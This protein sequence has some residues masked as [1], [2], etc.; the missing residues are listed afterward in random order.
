MSRVILIE[1]KLTKRGNSG[2]KSFSDRMIRI[3]EEGG[4]RAVEYYEMKN[5]SK[6]STPRGRLTINKR[7]C[8]W[9]PK[10]KFK[11]KLDT[12]VIFDAPSNISPESVNDFPYKDVSIFFDIAPDPKFIFCVPIDFSKW[13]SAFESACSA[14]RH[15]AI[16][17]NLPSPERNFIGLTNSLALPPVNADF[18]STGPSFLSP[19]NGANSSSTSFIELDDDRL[20]LTN[21][22]L[23]NRVDDKNESSN[24][25]SVLDEDK[26]KLSKSSSK[27]I[28]PLLHLGNLNSSP[29]S[30]EI[31]NA[32]Q[33][34]QPDLELIAA[35]SQVLQA[36]GLLELEHDPIEILMGGTLVKRGA[37]GLKRW[38]PRAFCLGRGSTDRGGATLTY[39]EEPDINAIYPNFN[40]RKFVNGLP[41][42]RGRLF[43]EPSTVIWGQDED[44]KGRR[45]VILVFRADTREIARSIEAMS[46]KAVLNELS[47]AKGAKFILAADSEEIKFQ[48]VDSIKK[49]VEN[50]LYYADDQAAAKRNDE[51]DDKQSIV[52]SS[53]GSLVSFASSFWASMAGANQSSSMNLSPRLRENQTFRLADNNNILDV[54]SKKS[55]RN[56]T[57]NI[58]SAQHNFNHSKNNLSIN[59]ISHS[60]GIMSALATPSLRHSPRDDK[61]LAELIHKQ[62]SMF[63]DVNE[64]LPR[65]SVAT[66]LATA[67]W[68]EDSCE[69]DDHPETDK[70][71]STAG[72]VYDNMIKVSNTEVNIKHE[73]E[74]QLHERE[75]VLRDTEEQLKI[76]SES[77]DKEKRQLQ[78]E[79]SAL[80][81]NMEDLNNEMKKLDESLIKDTEEQRMFNNEKI[82]FEV[83]CAERIQSLRSHEESAEK[84]KKTYE[85]EL[86]KLNLQKDHLTSEL[87]NFENLKYAFDCEK[88][89]LSDLKLT[90]DKE[91]DLF[92]EKVNDVEDKLKAFELRNSELS[93]AEF[94][95]KTEKSDFEVEK[96]NFKISTSN[97]Q[98]EKEEFSIRQITNDSETQQIISN[99]KKNMEELEAS[100]TK[101]NE[102]KIHSQLELECQN[103]AFDMMKKDFSTQ[104]AILKAEREGWKLRSLTALERIQELEKLTED[105]EGSS[106]IKMTESRLE[107]KELLEKIK[108]YEIQI[109]EFDIINRDLEKMKNIL[110]EKNK[111]LTNSVA[112][113]TSSANQCQNNSST[114]LV[115]PVNTYINR[116]QVE[117]ASLG[118]NIDRSMLVACVQQRIEDGSIS[119]GLTTP[120]GKF[121][122]AEGFEIDFSSPIEPIK[123]EILMEMM[124][125]NF[126][127]SSPGINSVKLKEKRL[128]RMFAALEGN[129]E[130]SEV[131]ENVN[132][133]SRSDF[134]K[135]A[136][137]SDSK[138]NNLNVSTTSVSDSKTKPQNILLWGKASYLDVNP[139]LASPLS[140]LIITGT[141]SSIPNLPNNL[142]PP[143]L[144]S[145]KATSNNF[146]NSASLVSSSPRRLN[147]GMVTMSRRSSISSVTSLNH[148][149]QLINSDALNFING[150]PSCIPMTSDE[151]PTKMV[152][153]HS[154]SQKFI[155][156]IAAL[157]ASAINPQAPNRLCIYRTK[158]DAISDL[159]A[160]AVVPICEQTVCNF[161]DG[162]RSFDPMN[163]LIFIASGSAPLRTAQ[164]VTANH[165]AN[166][167]ELIRAFDRSSGPK[168]TISIAQGGSASFFTKL[169]TLIDDWLFPFRESMLSFA[170]L[171]M[172]AAVSPSPPASILNGNKA[173]I[174]TKMQAPNLSLS[175]SSNSSIDHNYNDIATSKSDKANLLE[176]DIA[177]L[178]N[179]AE[180]SKNSENLI[181]VSKVD[182]Q[183]IVLNPPLEIK[184]LG[185][186]TIARRGAAEELERLRH[187]YHVHDWSED[188]ILP[189]IEFSIPPLPSY[190]HISADPITGF[191]G[192]KLHM[193]SEPIKQR[194][195]SNTANHIPNND[196]NKVDLHSE[197]RTFQIE[198][199][200]DF[201]RTERQG[202]IVSLISDSSSGAVASSP[203]PRNI[204]I[205]G[206][207]DASE[208][209][210]SSSTEYPIWLMTSGIPIMSKTSFKNPNSSS[211][212]L[213]SVINL[214]SLYV[215]FSQSSDPS[216]VLQQDLVN[217]TLASGQHQIV[218]NQSDFQYGQDSLHGNYFTAAD[219]DKSFVPP[220]KTVD[221]KQKSGKSTLSKTKSPTRL[222]SKVS[223]KQ[224]SVSPTSVTITNTNNKTIIHKNSEESTKSPSG[225]KFV[226]H[227]VSFASSAPIYSS[228]A[229]RSASTP[230]AN[231]FPFSPRIIHTP[232]NSI[233]LVND[234]ENIYHVSPNR[235]SMT[236]SPPPP[237]PPLSNA[238]LLP[239]PPT[240][241]TLTPFTQ[242]LMRQTAL[243]E[244][245]LIAATTCMDHG[246]SPPVMYERL[247]PH[248]AATPS[249]TDP[250]TEFYLSRDGSIRPVSPQSPALSTRDNLPVT[251][252]VREYRVPLRTSLTSTSTGGDMTN[253]FLERDQSSPVKCCGIFNSPSPNPVLR[254]FVPNAATEKKIGSNLVKEWNE[255]R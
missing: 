94:I 78:N 171:N 233:H 183:F 187:S 71:S 136:T 108:S 143:N 174:S 109:A 147:E 86:E 213:Q 21:S 127:D 67:P 119:T 110:E 64:Q 176:H 255:E 172:K 184:G 198:K 34:P 201:S 242:A 191:L 222:K 137:I 125:N 138:N 209:S 248:H 210:T 63:Q 236:V 111:D 217:D 14:A 180:V 161:K 140:N 96:Q 244:K 154:P 133:E 76:L 77:I 51:N 211:E 52:S 177:R 215:L 153:N 17:R 75:N 79:R 251:L 186:L 188:N 234:G 199:P 74:T 250:Q 65:Q 189:A 144:I 25:V 156:V 106:E 42:A 192:L 135:N 28:V 208:L 48:W 116:I 232:H 22:L 148:H 228:G 80:Q 151:F 104:D 20:I 31:V 62:E 124:L 175:V 169:K 149:K 194:V 46:A 122:A 24:L 196:D 13:Q 164:S 130:D 27:P 97:F 18:G 240:R 238:R 249:P 39:F 229:Q 252:S 7:T 69:D 33:H 12:I 54:Q 3:V 88:T 36:S 247:S 112:V 1:G 206:D 49:A 254:S 146:G 60:N 203:V 15:D 35:A 245:S 168:I 56:Q 128:S 179:Q 115:V 103:E 83:E 132:S 4:T 231:P 11:G 152:L 72:G 117:M 29:I 70:S 113:L 207:D 82:K 170:E 197:N 185:V 239:P 139:T 92:A 32:S 160:I 121:N 43:I 205:D 101:A 9:C 38:V 212:S 126:P 87:C 95:F 66:V 118:L 19:S 26:E 93:N 2:F 159:N 8:V 167:V 40:K 227:G 16:E 100:L 91:K 163:W 58:L 218:L 165:A 204:Y 223:K 230:L 53:A 59:K 89:S 5:F 41:N 129:S 193:I 214:T 81:Q 220:A 45:H 145:K 68:K 57:S 200:K 157:R 50:S 85:I 120:W 142:A 10:E 61:D 226:H 173:K 131:E 90:F 150:F 221:N 224:S 98:K 30:N 6:E 134:T 37:S 105:L 181:T 237:L 202:S 44:L 99:L 235:T 182:D 253:S 107:N 166:R 84:L 158:Q 141:S 123:N 243:E 195:L 23:E 241:N 114:S 47:K 216:L 219:L 190:V 246:R 155:P 162:K 73:K 55:P 102:E 178:S 225:A